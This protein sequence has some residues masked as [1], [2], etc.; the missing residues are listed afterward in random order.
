MGEVGTIHI[1]T[2]DRSKT[3]DPN[4]PVRVVGTDGAVLFLKLELL[5][6]N[7]QST[8]VELKNAVPLGD[9]RSGVNYNFFYNI[10]THI[11]NVQ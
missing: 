4:I 10:F 8:G 11:H 9:F 2:K 5:T 1:S 6:S 3:D 7:V